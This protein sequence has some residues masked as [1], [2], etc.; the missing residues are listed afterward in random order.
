MLPKPR[1]H[2][3]ENFGNVWQCPNSTEFESGYWW[4]FGRKNADALIGGH[5]YLHASQSSP[6]HQGGVVVGY[7][8]QKDGEFKGRYIFRFKPS[9]QHRGVVAEPGPWIGRYKQVVL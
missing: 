6:S 3:I 8:I 9:A 7:R 1:T 4:R 5:I 2:F